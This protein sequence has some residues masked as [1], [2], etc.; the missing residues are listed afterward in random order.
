MKRPEILAPAGDINCLKA[1]VL[2]GADAVYLGG[3][4][5]GARAFSNN[6]SQ[7]QILEAL[8]YAHS[9]GVKIYVTVNT[10]IYENEV[11]RFMN[12]IDF[13]YKSGVDAIII[14]DIGMMDLVRQTY[15]DLEMHASTQMHIHNLDG[16]KL[17]ENLGLKR[18]VLAR[19]LSLEEVSYIKNNTNI[20]IELFVH[21][22]LCISYSGQCLMSSLNGNRSGNRGT[23]V[24]S[25]RQNYNVLDENKNKVNI[26]NYNLSTKELMTINDITKL[27]DLGIDS[28]KIEGRMKS[29]EYVYLVVSAYKK[30]IDN[31]LNKNSSSLELEKENISKTFNRK[32]TKGFL[33][34]EDNDNFTNPFR[35]NHQGTILGKVI[36][37]TNTS[38]VIKLDDD[39]V[40]NDGIRIIGKEDTGF[41]VT[42]MF[43]EGSRVVE[44]KKNS[45]VYVQSD[46]NVEINSTVVKTTDYKLI[47]EIENKLKQEKRKVLINGEVKIEK[48]KKIILTVTDNKYTVT[49]E[50]IEI[51]EEASNVPTSKERIIEQITKTGSTIF[52]FDNLKTNIEENLFVPIKV[53]NEL[54]REALEM[55]E[56]QRNVKRNAYK[57][58]TYNKDLPDFEKQYSKSIYVQNIVQYNKIKDM[59]FEV[60]YL[61]SA[62][63]DQIEDNRKILK[64]PRVLSKYDTNEEELLV[65]E[66]GGIEKAKIVHTD[67]SLNV[68]NSYSIA[69]L[70]GIGVKK[71][72][73]SYELDDNQIE[74]MIKGYISRYN[75]K[76][77]L[78]MIIF[79]KEEVMITKFD[80][81]KYYKLD[82][83]GY[84]EDKYNNLYKLV[85]KDGIMYI[86][87]HNPRHLK[88]LNYYNEM[89]INSF[90]YNIVE[91]EDLKKIL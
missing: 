64:M 40:I 26:E 62:I 17:V 87:N 29:A 44:A 6:F 85:K 8:Q 61:D 88:N 55:L 75:K 71:I 2:A 68:V 70:H 16:V 12:Y 49:K 27:V 38:I 63:F 54:R 9:Y 47:K 58:E 36:D 82:N 56:Q 51:V 89:G 81:L 45:V 34:N 32:F 20:E 60:I 72:T 13:L 73:L 19:E 25:C 23:C 50:S 86:F 37:K 11:N 5:F 79:G 83:E 14:Q 78:E 18:V 35:P 7:E 21:G 91:N 90:R 42:S 10:I 76:P 24:G 84:L 48:N 15:P 57:K 31:Y 41:I 59:D 30:A 77:N 66:L 43:L 28:I 3:Q 39:L 22:A 74:D 46:H 67:F 4:M 65:G 52:E 53:I 1:A 33:F 69:F 80:L